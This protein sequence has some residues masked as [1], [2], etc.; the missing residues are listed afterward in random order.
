MEPHFCS[1]IE[2]C[3]RVAG[4]NGTEENWSQMWGWCQ[5]IFINILIFPQFPKLKQIQYIKQPIQSS[6]PNR[7][8]S[9]ISQECQRTV[10]KFPIST[11]GF[12]SFL[13][14]RLGRLGTPRS[15]MGWSRVWFWRI[16]SRFA[17]AD[18]P[19]TC[20]YRSCSKHKKYRPTTT[21]PVGID[22]FQQQMVCTADFVVA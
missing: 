13:D 12:I 1:E 19:I 11:K 8:W 17:R 9:V 18:H 14:E 22:P 10:F 3:T 6:I 16:E 15:C 21:A 2:L 5:R 20:S 4:S 7:L